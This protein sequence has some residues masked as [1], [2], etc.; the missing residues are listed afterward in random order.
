[1]KETTK[2]CFP[3]DGGTKSMVLSSEKCKAQNERCAPTKKGE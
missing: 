3:T 2:T 1:M